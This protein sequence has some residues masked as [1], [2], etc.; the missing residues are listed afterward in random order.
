MA[1]ASC[2][3]LTGGR[4]LTIPDSTAQSARSP[5][6]RRFSSSVVPRSAIVARKSSTG[7][8]AMKWNTSP[9]Y[10]V[11]RRVTSPLMGVTIKRYAAGAVLIRLADE[12]ARVALVLLALQRTHSAAVG[13][14]LVAALLV[15]HVVAAPVAGLLTDRAGSPRRVLAAAALVFAAALAA[16]SAALG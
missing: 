11:T 5:G 6:A 10:P 13:G 16:V 1:C 8:S 12:G 4:L 14:A 2:A 3:A 9:V 15:P 7:R